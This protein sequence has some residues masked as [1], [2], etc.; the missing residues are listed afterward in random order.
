ME[1]PTR[2]PGDELLRPGAMLALR[3]RL[4]SM[5]PR[6]DLA[7]V[8]VNAF[9][10]RTRMPPFLY[11]DT[12]MAPAG[13]RAIG[14][15]MA[16][17]GLPKTRIVLQ[18]WNRHFRPSQMLLDGRIPDLFMVSSMLL[19]AERCDALLRDACRIDPGRRPLIIAGGPLVAYEPWRVF[20]ADRDHLYGADVA[21][22]GEEY[23]L[24]ELLE[25]LLTLRAGNEPLRAA[26]RLRRDQG[27]LDHVPGLVYAR[28]DA[29]GVPLELVDT[30]IQRLLGD[31][32]E[33]P[34][35][36]LGYRLLEPPGRRTTLSP[37]ALP[38]SRVLRH[39]PVASLVLTQG[40]RFRCP[41]CAIPAY[42]QRQFRAKSGGSPMKS[43]RCTN[44]TASGWPSAPMTTSS[45]I[46]TG[47]WTSP[48][49]WLPG[50]TRA[51]SRTAS[52]VGEPRPRSTIRSR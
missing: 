11:A 39:T 22:T 27:A 28:T 47:P 15:A 30:G 38:A 42:N 48:R 9:D 46:P 44:S 17:V 18:Q 34:D 1:L 23:V 50:W 52:S 32:D 43:S 31:F 2:T 16:D 35:P 20:A 49:H 5:T 36:A 26:F 6:H 45:P 24:L 21:V 51:A 19:H 3:Q 41:Y 14:T 13:V 33:L 8:I 12:L 25:V 29:Q 4:R 40:C 37:A 7:T 10:H